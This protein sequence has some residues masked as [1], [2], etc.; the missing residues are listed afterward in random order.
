MFSQEV[1]HFGVSEGE[2]AEVG[3]NVVTNLLAHV[4][5][6]DFLLGCLELCLKALIGLAYCHRK[7]AEDQAEG[8][9]GYQYV[10]LGGFHCASSGERAQKRQAKLPLGR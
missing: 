6:L 4:T 9:Q 10:V 3:N 5:A 1:F 2:I 7:D 8:P